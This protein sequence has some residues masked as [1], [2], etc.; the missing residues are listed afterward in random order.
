[1]RNKGK[2]IVEK[3]QKYE[4]YFE[5]PQPQKSIDY[6]VIQVENVS[7]NYPKRVIFENLNFGISMD[8]RVALV[9]PN[10]AG[11]T[12]LLELLSGQLVPTEGYI[13]INKQITI[14]YFKQHFTD[15]LV[16]NLTPFQYLTQKF[17][18]ISRECKGNPYRKALGQFGLPGKTHN[19]PISS[20]SGGQKAR[21]VLATISLMN[22]D[23]LFLDEPTNHL[24]MESV[25]AL[26]SALKTYK[27]GVVIISHNID[28]INS[29]CHDI[30]V[31][32]NSS[33]KKYLTASG[34]SGN[35]YDYRQHIID[36]YSD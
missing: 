36:Q 3:V 26:I 13:S 31:V 6:P 12:T 4:V 28:F 9:G 29:I 35:I 25:E 16:L 33:V 15:Q 7:F 18:N 14:G 34:K 2:N 1:M 27:G 24:D 21:V 30:W 23:I 17:P 8:T 11:K 22:P 10:G 20:L 5:F 19:Q 32:E